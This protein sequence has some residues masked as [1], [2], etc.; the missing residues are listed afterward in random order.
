MFQHM[1][2]VTDKNSMSDDAANAISLSSPFSDDPTPPTVTPLHLST[3]ETETYVVLVIQGEM[4]IV[5]TPRV[6]AGLV[7]A[8]ALAGRRRLVL[9]LRQTD[10]LDSVG[11]TALVRFCVHEKSRHSGHIPG[12]VL[13]QSSQVERI[14]TVSRFDQLFHVGYSVEEALRS[15]IR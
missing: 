10:Y 7:D 9:D 4:D 15:V 12:V 14:L 2:L 5:S 8:F 6:G 11:L 13:T 1:N 3:V